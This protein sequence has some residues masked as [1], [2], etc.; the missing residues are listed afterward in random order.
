MASSAN[1]SKIM[2]SSSL[3]KPVCS[4]K[5]SPS[6][7][8]S[9][10]LSTFVATAPHSS[11]PISSSAAPSNPSPIPEPD[12]APSSPIT[13]TPA[14]LLSSSSIALLPITSSPSTNDHRKF[15]QQ[16]VVSDTS[17]VAG[18]LVHEEPASSTF[19]RIPRPCFDQLDL[20]DEALISDYR[21][22]FD[23]FDTCST[24]G[25]VITCSSLGPNSATT[26]EPLSPSYCS[27][28]PPFEHSSH[29]RFPA[30]PTAPILTSTH[31]PSGLRSPRRWSSPLYSLG[32]PSADSLLAR[33]ENDVFAAGFQAAL[34]HMSSDQACTR[35]GE[36]CLSAATAPP[37][38]HDESAYDDLDSH[39]HTITTTNL[40]SWIASEEEGERKERAAA[41][42]EE[43][44][45]YR[46]ARLAGPIGCDDAPK[47][48]SV[49]RQL[50]SRRSHPMLRLD[51][52]DHSRTSSSAEPS[53]TELRV[54]PDPDS[55]FMRKSKSAAGLPIRPSWQLVQLSAINYQSILKSG[56]LL[57][58]V[59]V[60]LDLEDTP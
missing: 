13:S 58:E 31:V 6:Q 52:L 7:P 39:E 10:L 1:P 47:L 35:W 20:I 51:H 18:V 16:S 14:P 53:P 26:I 44:N 30:F 29:K 57:D 59:L 33:E 60:G 41:A 25:S 42:A 23:S 50:I 27:E 21:P 54:A 38:T 37:T 15:R 28:H 48:S 3:S 8:S 56:N 17:L 11:S 40:A 36:D 46:W 43:D 5:T 19:L 34:N 32:S 24:S 4:I 12:P 9:Q 45:M 55:P 22:S 49:T 2:T